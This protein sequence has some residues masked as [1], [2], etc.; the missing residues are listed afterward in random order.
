MPKSS[1]HPPRRPVNM[2]P[3]HMHHCL[4]IHRRGAAAAQGS[5]ARAGERFFVRRGRAT[6]AYRVFSM[7][8]IYY[9]THVVMLMTLLCL[10]VSCWRRDAARRGVR[11]LIAQLRTHLRLHVH[12]MCLLFSPVLSS[13]R[14]SL[15]FHSSSNPLIR[16]LRVCARQLHLATYH[17]AIPKGDASPSSSTT[18]ARLGLRPP[19]SPCRGARTSP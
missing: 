3:V 8:L 17:P 14:L 6:L 18:R 4:T 19:P 16:H 2:S 11:S 13:T 9:G 1:G 10:H 12:P 5:E 15:L 7:L